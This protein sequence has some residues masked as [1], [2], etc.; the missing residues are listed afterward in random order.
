MSQRGFLLPGVLMHPLSSLLR[1]QHRVPNM[2]FLNRTTRTAR[3]CIHQSV[4]MWTEVGGAL[5]LC[6]SGVKSRFSMIQRRW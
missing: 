3:F 4:K 5:T 1:N 2:V 6:F